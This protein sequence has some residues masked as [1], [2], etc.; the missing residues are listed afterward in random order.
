MGCLLGERNRKTCHTFSHLTVFFLLGLDRGIEI[1]EGE[2][3]VLP[4]ACLCFYVVTEVL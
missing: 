4:N 1:V 2:C 3:E